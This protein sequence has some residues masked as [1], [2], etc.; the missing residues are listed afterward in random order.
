MLL[1]NPHKPAEK[2][3]GRCGLAENK[4]FTHQC[5][6]NRA[7]AQELGYSTEQDAQ[8]SELKLAQ[9]TGHPNK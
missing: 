8:K 2:Q 1:R 7:S 4:T 9:R 5:Q 3:P 6:V